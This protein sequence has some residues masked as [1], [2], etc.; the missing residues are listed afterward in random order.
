MKR[1]QVLDEYFGG[2][3]LLQSGHEVNRFGAD[4]SCCSKNIFPR[5]QINAH[6]ASSLSDDVTLWHARLGHLPFGKL[7]SLGL[8]STKCS[9]DV[10][11]QYLICSKAR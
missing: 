3:Y 1:P 4:A 7:L 6:T 2:L 10:I 5:T 11:R 8:F 9:A